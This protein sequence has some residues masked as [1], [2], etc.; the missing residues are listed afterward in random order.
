MSS[1]LRSWL[2][3]VGLLLVLLACLL[4]LPFVVAFGAARELLVMAAYAVL[5][6]D[7]PRRE[8]T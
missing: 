8:P 6:F 4:V 5:A 1:A 2:G 7:D 3:F